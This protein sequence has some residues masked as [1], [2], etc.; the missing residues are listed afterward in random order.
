MTSAC[1][2]NYVQESLNP[3]D[4]GTRE[5]S[6][7]NCDS[8]AL[9]LRGPPF[10]LQR[11]LEPQPA[12]PAVI[13]R[14]AS[15]NVDRLSVKSKTCL[16]RIIKSTPYL[17]T[18]KKRVAYLIAFTQYIVAKFQKCNLGKPKLDADCLD[19]ALMDVAK[20]V[21]RFHFEDA[22]RLLQEKSSDASDLI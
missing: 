3:A 14:S 5:D 22:I 21:Q 6:V 11:S 7:K 12:S 9:W 18:L 17:Y 4:I 16:D 2:W 13:V 8:F 10:L 19:N 1:D 20:F 15:I